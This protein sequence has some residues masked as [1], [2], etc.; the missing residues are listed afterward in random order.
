M[1]A[2]PAWGGVAASG[3]ASQDVIAAAMREALVGLAWE[4]DVGTFARLV[5]PGVSAATTQR[6]QATVRGQSAQT[7]RW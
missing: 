7:K 5:E 2:A 6:A 1:G 3:G 4:T